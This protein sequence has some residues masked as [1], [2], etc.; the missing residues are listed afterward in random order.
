MHWEPCTDMFTV[1]HMSNTHVTSTFTLT[2]VAAGSVFSSGPNLRVFNPLWTFTRTLSGDVDSTHR[3]PCWIRTPA[4]ERSFIM[5][6][7]R[8]FPLSYFLNHVSCI[9]TNSSTL[10]FR[11]LSFAENVCSYMQV[12]NLNKYKLVFFVFS[13]DKQVQ[14]HRVLQETKNRRLKVLLFLLPFGEMTEKSGSTR[15]K[16]NI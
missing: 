13:P 8:V 2:S 16:M 15:W 14:I 4:R 5:P 7:K 10:L 1:C 12:K 11:L 9:S 6:K 3:G